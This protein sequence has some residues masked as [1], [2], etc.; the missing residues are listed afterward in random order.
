MLLN[1]AISEKK[2]N[3]GTFVCSLR[4]RA[5]YERETKVAQAN[6]R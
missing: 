1:R 4:K 2:S 3:S 6:R 5:A